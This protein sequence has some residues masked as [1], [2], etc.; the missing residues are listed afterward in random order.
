MAPPHILRTNGEVY[1]YDYDN[2][3]WLRVPHLDVPV[4]VSEIA[5][6]QV[7]TVITHS[8]EWWY[9]DIGAGGTWE[10]M[11]RPDWVPIL[12]CH[13]DSDV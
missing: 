12:L 8:G 4:P 2:A 1:Q 10:I 9:E 6:W 11:P 7:G 13:P 5:D 3:G